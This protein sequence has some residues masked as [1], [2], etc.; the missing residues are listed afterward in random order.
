M[1]GGRKED[2]GREGL[3]P[4]LGGVEREAADGPRI[5]VRELPAR[6]A[7]L[8]VVGRGPQGVLGVAGTTNTGEGGREGGREA[9]VRKWHR[10]E[11]VEFHHDMHPFF[12]P[13]L[14]PSLPPY[15]IKAAWG[16][17]MTLIGSRAISLYAVA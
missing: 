3:L 17:A 11:D 4:V 14:P 13:S 2:G 12:L 10:Q 9:V 16:W 15:R 6:I 5:L 7:F 1:K 8:G